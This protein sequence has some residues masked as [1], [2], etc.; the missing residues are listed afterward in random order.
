MSKKKSKKYS[1]STYYLYVN[2]E[3]INIFPKVLGKYD[4]KRGQFI[5]CLLNIN[6]HNMPILSPPEN[7]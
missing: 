7:F 2:F 6:L 1:I 4:T 3:P 5:D